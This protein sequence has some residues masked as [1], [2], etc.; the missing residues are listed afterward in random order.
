MKS[1]LIALRKFKLERKSHNPF[2]YNRKKTDNIM[3][4]NNQIL[5]G[6]RLENKIRYN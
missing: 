6:E 1:K 2:I 3:A 4:K 5:T